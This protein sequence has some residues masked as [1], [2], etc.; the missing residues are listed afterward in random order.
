MAKLQVPIISRRT[1]EA[2]TVGE[3]GEGLG[4]TDDCGFLR[5]QMETNSAVC[6]SI[7]PLR[8]SLDATRA[9]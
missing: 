3:R 2:L 5:T 4:S 8:T 6:S 1:V 7:E 9:S